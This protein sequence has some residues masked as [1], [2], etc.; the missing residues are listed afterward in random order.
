MEADGRGAVGFCDPKQKS[1]S[2]SVSKSM[3]HTITQEMFLMIVPI[4]YE[5]RTGVRPGSA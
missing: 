4:S 3:I 2:I 5:R 1:S